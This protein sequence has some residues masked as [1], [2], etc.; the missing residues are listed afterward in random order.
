M[1]RVWL[2]ALGVA[3]VG[4]LALP[5]TGSA[6]VSA[7]HRPVPSGA[8]PKAHAA[9]LPVCLLAVPE[10]LDA[11][12]I[13]ATAIVAATATT[14]VVEAP[15]V[16]KVTKVALSKI[17]DSVKTIQNKGPKFV[18]RKWKKLPKKARQCLWGIAVFQTSQL[19]FHKR[20]TYEQ[21][22]SFV[23][24]YMPLAPTSVYFTPAWNWNQK[25]RSAYPAACLAG[26]LAGYAPTF[27][28]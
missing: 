21:W 27:L 18:K 26:I 22:Q 3:V 17:F 4:A 7:R 19:R 12:D 16:Y 14:A 1:K 25:S 20:I 28:E 2:L 8:P 13:V 11:A 9:C 24:F 23:L 10:V 5:A 15:T 6:H